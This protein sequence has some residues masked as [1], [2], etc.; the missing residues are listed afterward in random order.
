MC[1]AVLEQLIFLHGI[2]LILPGPVQKQISSFAILNYRMVG[3]YFPSLI[4]SRLNEVF[5]VHIWNLIHLLPDNFDVAIFLLRLNSLVK[6][7]QMNLQYQEQ[8]VNGILIEC[9]TKVK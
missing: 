6:V 7:A 1:L 3:K 9:K 2:L 4:V 5:E 8:I